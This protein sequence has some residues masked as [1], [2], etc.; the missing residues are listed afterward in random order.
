M[1]RTSVFCLWGRSRLCGDI[2]K[3]KYGVTR[4][5]THNVTKSE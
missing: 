1:I 5:V 3:F 4:N 2:L